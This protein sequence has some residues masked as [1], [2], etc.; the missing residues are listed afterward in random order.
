MGIINMT[1]DSF[2]GDGLLGDAAA[3]LRQGEAMVRDG[4]D[5]LDVGGESTRPGHRPVD[6]AT[7]LRRVL[8]AVERLAHEL[9]VPISIDT[10]RGSVA[11]A[12]LDA[13]ASIINDVTALRDDPGLADLA[14]ERGCP[15]ILSHWTR[16]PGTPGQDILDRVAADLRA[17]VEQA[18]SA[19]VRPEQIVV[20]PGIGF[21]KGPQESLELMRRLR[22]LKDSLGCPVLVGPSRK[23]SIGAVLG[24]LPPEE[25]VEGTGAAIALCIAGGADIVRVHD[26][27]HMV[28]VARV[29]DA[30]VRG[31][32]LPEAQAERTRARR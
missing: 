29:A 21:G 2:S 13:G 32:E 19:G 14:A 5:L 25:R 1:P 7:E 15:L 4:A 8:S 3:A 6:A 12:A 26:V 16:G 27:R 17:S 20:D 10:R 24:G 30:I 23:S 22:E 11:R 28:R 9:P 18:R 31:W